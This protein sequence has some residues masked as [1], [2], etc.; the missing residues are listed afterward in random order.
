MSNKTSPTARRQADSYF[1][2]C[3]PGVEALLHAELRA[4]KLG[5][6]ERQVGGVYFEGSERDC[7]R[8]N[9]HLRTAVRVLRRLA[10]FQ[11]SGSDE[12]YDCAS[13]VAWEN[14]LPIGATL[15]VAAHTKD[16]TLDHS[17]FIEQRVKDAICDALL[18]R[19][20]ARPTVD[21]QRPD[22]RVHAHY[23]RDRCTLLVDTSGESLARRGWRR[24]TGR[25]PM[26]ETLAAAV[27]MHSGWDCRSP[28]I[29]PFCGSGTL[30]VEALL[31]ATGKAPGSL[32]ER[33]AFESFPDFDARLWRRLLDEARGLERPLGKLRIVGS[34]LDGATLEGAAKNLA[35]AGFE[36]AVQ[37]EVRDAA[38]F[39]P[40]RGWNGWVVT[41]PPYGERLGRSE[42][43]L[44]L[45][46]AFGER[47]RASCEGYSLAL[48]SGAE[49][50]SAALELGN[51]ERHGITNGALECELLCAKL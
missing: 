15:L 32:R 39:A 19:R 22:L 38:H 41:N 12:L 1:V 40:K 50:L 28:L 43:L 13:Q 42:D 18:E 49:D 29:D 24:F 8:A 17:H 14:W 9:L 33:F 48:L 5:R 6:V 21:K 34:D 37:L 46:R 16:S 10:R 11:A 23:Y 7:M 3:A 26:A 2:T 31:L 27:L 51:A 36:G 47:L 30:F 20:G 25:A 44:G 35:A 4:L 45:Y